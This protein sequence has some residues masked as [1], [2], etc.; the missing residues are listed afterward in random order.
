V[1]FNLWSALAT[2]TS[3]QAVEARRQAEFTAAALSRVF[4]EE[5]F[6][7]VVP[8]PARFTWEENAVVVPESVGWLSSPLPSPSYEDL[9]VLLR[10][11]LDSIARQRLALDEDGLRQALEPLLADAGTTLPKGEVGTARSRRGERSRAKWREGLEPA[12]PLMRSPDRWAERV[13]Q[14]V[15][16]AKPVTVEGGKLS[17]LRF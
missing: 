13:F 4:Q 1:V 8:P 14:T 17:R 12:R 11:K 9:D 10:E 5:R 3:R 15:T 7:K 6:L 16:S 2:A